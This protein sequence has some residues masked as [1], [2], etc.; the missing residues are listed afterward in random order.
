MYRFKKNL[1]FLIVAI[2]LIGSKRVEAQT[3]FDQFKETFI[4]KYSFVDT[5]GKWGNFEYFQRKSDGQIAYCIEPGLPKSNESYMGKSDLKLNELAEFVHLTEEQLYQVSL[6]AYFGYGY[7]GN[8]G[9]EWIVATQALIW[10]ALGRDFHFTSRIDATHPSQYIIDTP[11]EIQNKMNA[12]EEKIAWYLRK[13][14]FNQKLQIAYKTT[15]Q[16]QSEFLE[17]FHLKDTYN[18][19]ANFSKNHELEIRPNS[20]DGGRV[21]LQKE[22]KD[23]LHYFVVYASDLGQNMFVPGNLPPLEVSLDFEVVRNVIHLKKYDAI[24]RKCDAQLNTS[25]MGSVY[26]LYTY[27]GKHIQDL[28][29]DVHCSAHFYDLPN[30]KYY[31]QEI[32]PGLNY[33]LDPNQYYFEFKEG[34]FE[35]EVISYEDIPKGQI[36]LKKMDSK[37]KSCLAQGSA[38][39]EGAIYGIYQKDGRLVEEL[40]VKNCEALSKKD[41]PIG[42]YYVKEIKAPQ[43]YMKDPKQY[44][45]KITALN[46]DTII[47]ISVLEKV[48]E[49]E[50]ILNKYYLKNNLAFQEEGAEFEIFLDN[51]RIKTI[52]TNAFGQASIVLPYGHYVI[53]QVKAL[54]GYHLVASFSFQVNEDSQEKESITLYNKPFKGR[55]ELLKLDYVT[56]APLSQAKFKI[57]KE[58]GECFDELETDKNGLININDLEYGTYYFQEIKAPKGYALNQNKI[59]FNISKDEDLVLLKAYN[60]QEV[61]V[62]NTLKEENRPFLLF[63]LVVGVI[64]YK[65]KF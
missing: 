49:T 23:W 35:Q 57:C 44:S 5:K 30:G 52:K 53:K 21:V 10:K 55:V 4:G 3:V 13:P 20:L 7:Q 11:E 15:Y 12:I 40:K 26:G 8:T 38:T 51:R 50:L 59:Y 45:F 65:K 24:S 19:T 22:T 14:D 41:L 58:M 54:E 33:A 29:I 2:L 46:V 61:N 47:T 25:L 60:E 18:A 36:R 32:Q 27:D 42:E 43:G 63:L 48:Y 62:P 1:V 39:L 56:D 16:Y 28:V 31:I 34:Q 6:I 37:N 17:N 64:L 9:N